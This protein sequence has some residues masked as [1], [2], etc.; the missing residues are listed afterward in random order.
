MKMPSKATGLLL[1]LLLGGLQTGC[2]LGREHPAATQPATAIDPKQAQPAY[3]LDQPAVVK[4]SSPDFDLLWN[5]CRDSAEAD[6]F[7][8]DRTDY[9]DG[10]LTTLPLPSRQVYEF[11]RGDIATHRDLTQSTLG[12]MRRTIHF[13]IRRLDD[14]SFEATPKVL[15]ERDSLIERRITSVDQYQ[16]VF[17]IQ[18]VDVAR[19]TEKTGDAVQPEYWY[20]VARD[21]A[22]ERKLAD[23][24]RRRLHQIR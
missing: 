23:A 16:A 12:S 19:E 22:L 17:S 15:V 9:R 2:I 18:T 20:S 5:A 8:I 14:G 4:M 13:A 21:F 3:W 7:T 11:W 10:V 1:S 6:G 24:V